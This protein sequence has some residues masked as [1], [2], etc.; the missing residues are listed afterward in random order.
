VRNEKRKKGGVQHHISL[1]GKQA[2]F[3]RENTK[4]E[5]VLSEIKKTNLY[6]G[7][8]L[9]M[10]KIEKKKKKPGRRRKIKRSA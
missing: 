6:Q 7:T 9:R 8:K 3:Q 10:S 5:R 1:G 4:E 2:S